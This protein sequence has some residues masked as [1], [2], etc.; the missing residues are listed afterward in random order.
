MSHREAPPGLSL[1][2]APVNGSE[3]THVAVFPAI[4]CRYDFTLPSREINKAALLTFGN[5]QKKSSSF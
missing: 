5:I 2:R 4:L 3:E 1:P